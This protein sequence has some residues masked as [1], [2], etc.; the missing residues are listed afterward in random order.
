MTGVANAQQSEGPYIAP[1]HIKSMIGPHQEIHQTHDCQTPVCQR[2]EPSKS[3]CL[4]GRD[5]WI[6]THQPR[7]PSLQA[8]SG[9]YRPRLSCGRRLYGSRQLGHLAEWRGALRLCFAVHRFVFQSDGGLAAKLCGPS[10]HCQRTGSRAGLPRS[11]FG[12]GDRLF[13]A[14]GGTGHYRHRSG[15]SD[16]HRHRP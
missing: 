7:P 5:A 8:L 9:L 13:M 6:G 4:F 3:A 2:L 1:L 14:H 10:G 12:A 16:R 15:R 11:V